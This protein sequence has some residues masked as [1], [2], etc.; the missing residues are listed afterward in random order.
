MSDSD[1][2]DSIFTLNSA[3]V[4]RQ[5]SSRCSQFT[6]V[7]VCVSAAPKVDAEQADGPAALLRSA[8][9]FRVRTP[10]LLNP[11]KQKK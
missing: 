6:R 2:S 11:T 9:A 5:D 8:A 1:P 7:D 4:Q 3:E 10:D